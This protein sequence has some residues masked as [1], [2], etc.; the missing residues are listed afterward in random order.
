MQLEKQSD[1]PSAKQLESGVQRSKNR[2]HPFCDD[3]GAG[4]IFGWY[5]RKFPLRILEIPPE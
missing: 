4:G 2:G 3:Y 5:L 1:K